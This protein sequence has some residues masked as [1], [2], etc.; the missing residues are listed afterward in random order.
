LSGSALSSVGSPGRLLAWLSQ[1]PTLS[2]ELDP[3]TI[4]QAVSE[5]IEKN[6]DLVAERFNL[7]IAEAR[8]I[9]STHSDLRIFFSDFQADA[10]G[11]A[12]GSASGFLK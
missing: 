6:L 2:V 11:T 8:L 3:L 1:A 4:D 9:V 10:Q 5:A 7:P 12:N